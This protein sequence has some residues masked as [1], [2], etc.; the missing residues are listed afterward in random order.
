MS[1]PIMAFYDI[2][3]QMPYDIKYANMGI[4]TTV[5]IRLFDIQDIKPFAKNKIRQK[6]K[7]EFKI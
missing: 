7:K 3:W 1:R 5:L 2:S 4:K 6:I